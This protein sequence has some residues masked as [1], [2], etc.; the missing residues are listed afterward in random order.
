MSQHDF[1][2]TT[3]DAN[4]GAT[5]RA[6]INAGLQALATNSAA[7][8]EPGTKYPF[9]WWADTTTDTLKQ[10]NAA[11]T[12]WVSVLKLSTGVAVAASDSVLLGG[13]KW[14]TKAQ[15][16]TVV[17]ANTATNLGF[18]L[19]AGHTDIRVSIYGGLAPVYRH[20]V[21]ASWQ[22]TFA[23]Y[24]TVSNSQ[25]IAGSG[26]V[27]LYNGYTSADTFYYKIDVWE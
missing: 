23:A 15:S 10:R 3:A 5:M 24:Y 18:L 17:A 12:A 26:T 25:S 22:N 6:A 4:T 19:P 16:S 8:G 20:H 2:I 11:N 14:V 21:P 7:T 27:T 9:M 1:D 13:K